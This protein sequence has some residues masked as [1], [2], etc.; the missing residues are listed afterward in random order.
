MKHKHLVN[1]ANKC[2]YNNVSHLFADA[3]LASTIYNLVMKDY[4]ALRCNVFA[5]QNS[6]TFNIHYFDLS[7]N[8][9]NKHYNHLF[10]LTAEKNQ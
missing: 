10:Q 3:S 2:I 6:C 4:I 1:A 7:F 8:N 9:I 5:M